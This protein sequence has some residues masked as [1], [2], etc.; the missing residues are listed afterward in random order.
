MEKEEVVIK[1]LE[2]SRIFVSEFDE[3]I[4]LSIQVRMGSARCI[5]KRDQAQLLLEELQ[6]LL[7]Q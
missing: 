6:K 4:W 2:D 1:G 7:E 3:D 5:L